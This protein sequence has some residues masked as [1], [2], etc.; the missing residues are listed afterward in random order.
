LAAVLCAAVLRVAELRAAAL[1]AVLLLAEERLAVLRV[2]VLRWYAPRLCALPRRRCAP[3]MPCFA[4]PCP[5]PLCAW[6]QSCSFSYMTGAGGLRYSFRNTYR[7][8]FF[9]FLPVQA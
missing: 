2:A 9:L 1:C 4:W 7:L 5:A 8:P 6:R 3:L